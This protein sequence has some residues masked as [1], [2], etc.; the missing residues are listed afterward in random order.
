MILA[1]PC[2]NSAHV[3]N[4]CELARSW[5]TSGTSR[6]DQP[7]R[8]R[9]SCCSAR[10]R[11]QP[12]TKRPRHSG[13]QQSGTCSRHQSG[14]LSPTAHRQRHL[15][16]QRSGHDPLGRAPGVLLHGRARRSDFHR[17]PGPAS[18]RKC[19]PHRSA[20]LSA[21]DR[22]KIKAAGFILS[23]R[24]NKSGSFYA[25][26]FR[27]YAAAECANAAPSPQIPRWQPQGL[28]AAHPARP[29]HWAPYHR[30]RCAHR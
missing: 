17:G 11:T 22:L 10:S 30:A 6:R 20:A 21:A 23:M 14:A 19:Q 7:W 24:K 9:R 28:S 5:R 1:T 15:R 2:N 8:C 27:K 3:R 18:G 25:A 16:D 29:H 4:P 12:R 13:R 26:A